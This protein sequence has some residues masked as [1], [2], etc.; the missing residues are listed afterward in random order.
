M[1]YKKLPYEGLKAF[2]T[3]VYYGYGFPRQESEEI[4]DV[5]LCADLYGFESHGVQRLIRYH[6]SM[7][8][9]NIDPKAEPEILFETP[10]SAVID[11]KR[12]AGQK[13]ALFAMHTA[14]EKAQKQ[15]A[16][17]VTMRNAN[18]YGIASYYA[19]M[20]AKEKLIGLS[21]TNSEAMM[22]PTYGRN[23]MLGSNPIAVAMPA[24][25]YV[26]SFDAATT[27][28]PRGKLEVYEKQEKPLPYG[29]AV[30]VDGLES[31]DSTRIL[32]NII[33]KAGGGIL[34]VGG[35][36]PLN[37]SHKGYGYGMICEIFT[38]ILSGGPTSNHWR[39]GETSQG[40][41]A[42]DYGMFG[43]KKEIEERMSQLLEELRESDK[44]EGQTRIYT[45]G[46][47]EQE[48]AKE[49]QLS[50]IPVNE[51]TEGELREIAAY[52]KL[53]YESYIRN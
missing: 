3:D 25:P 39:R 41:I 52:L 37:G 31:S 48:S 29:W 44:A 30:D 28:I 2:C 7:L 50:G 46:E 14:I 15:G 18:H 49:K 23:A 36:D 5:I 11:A 33:H 40:F 6:K 38:S 42:I 17:F 43:D 20:A 10:I 51:K 45:H 8:E 22:V 32:Q 9:G 12:G 53:D 27:V 1:T 4:A 19:M 35:S 26:F 34:P 47:K 24:K 16:G 13:M 21:F